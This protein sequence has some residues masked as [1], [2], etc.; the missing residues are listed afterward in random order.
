MDRE[1]LGGSVY[2]RRG[3]QF[4]L[5]LEGNAG[6]SSRPVWETTVDWVRESVAAMLPHSNGAHY[7]NLPGGVG[8]GSINPVWS[9]VA[10][11]QDELDPHGVFVK[12]NNWSG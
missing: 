5:G 1:P 4:L 10:E 8:E 6:V 11:L 7:V 3:A 12:P 9:A 2:P